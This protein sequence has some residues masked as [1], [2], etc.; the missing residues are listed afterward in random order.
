MKTLAREMEDIRDFIDAKNLGS[1]SRHQAMKQL[2][3]DI[4]Q[5]IKFLDSREQDIRHGT[6]F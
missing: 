6:K 4:Y 3:R 2:P 1:K 5:A